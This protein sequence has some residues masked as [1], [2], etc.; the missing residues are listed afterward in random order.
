MPVLDAVEV[1]VDDSVLL[2]VKV[3]DADGVGEPVNVGL[4]LGVTVPDAETEKDAVLVGLCDCVVDG[5]RYCD[6]V[7]VRVDEAVKVSL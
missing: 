3:P 4:T 1:I 5:L 7:P 2:V 6:C